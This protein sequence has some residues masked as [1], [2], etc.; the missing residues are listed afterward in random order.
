M[1]RAILAHHLRNAERGRSRLLWLDSSD[2]HGRAYL[3]DLAWARRYAELNRRHVLQAA[4]GALARLFGV[5]PRW[6]A[7]STCDHNHVRREPH[8]GGELLVHRKGAISASPGEPG[9]LPGSMGTAT[10]H[11]TGRGEPLALRSSS[12]GAGRAFSRSEARERIRARDLRREMGRV[13]FDRARA[14]RLVD[15]APSAY[16]DVRAVMRAQRD[17]VRIERR[18]RPP[19]CYKG[20]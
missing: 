14:A 11:V 2:E 1:G 17:L 13:H 18:L 4:A 10:Y 6:D 19:L 7:L 15:Q 8:F 5:E 12:H 9:I 16:R 3:D 20:L